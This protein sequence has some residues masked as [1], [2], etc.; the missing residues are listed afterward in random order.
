MKCF[1]AENP[2]GARG[3]GQMMG[4]DE[5][6]GVGSWM[7]VLI[8]L[9]KKNYFLDASTHHYKRVCPSVGWLVG[10][11]VGPLVGQFFL[12]TENTNIMND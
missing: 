9:W 2:I 6:H 4:L 11:F 3:C 7:R 5:E 10:P 12:M 8:A 1:E